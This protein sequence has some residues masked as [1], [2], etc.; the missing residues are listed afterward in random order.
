M[1][2]KLLLLLPSPLLSAAGPVPI[3]EVCPAMWQPAQAPPPEPDCCRT[4]RQTGTVTGRRSR[5][6]VT[7]QTPLTGSG[8]R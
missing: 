1:R 8:W 2:D 7:P 6:R 4:W 3:S 5:S